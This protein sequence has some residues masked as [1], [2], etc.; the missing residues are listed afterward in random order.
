MRFA[1]LIIR[2][3]ISPTV[4]ADTPGKVPSR[5][6]TASRLIS[7]CR[8]SEIIYNRLES[9][10]VVLAMSHNQPESPAT[11]M[12]MHL[13][14]LSFFLFLLNCLAAPVTPANVV[15]IITDDQD[16][17]LDGMVKCFDF[18]NICNNKGSFK[19]YI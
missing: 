14:I 3:S 12:K 11:P 19:F 4:H 2:E 9:Q 10:F 17:T 6:R 13:A 8:E 1:I 5:S 16:S 18:G 7:S 15:L